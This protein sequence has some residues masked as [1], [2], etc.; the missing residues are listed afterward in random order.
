MLVVCV[1]V[2]AVMRLLR[3]SES[4]SVAGPSDGCSSLVALMLGLIYFRDTMRF[5]IPVRRHDRT[6]P[7]RACG[8][9]WQQFPTAVAPVPSEGSFAIAGTTALA[10][11]ALARRLVRVPRVR[12][13]RG[14]RARR[15]AVHLHRRRSAPIATECRRGAVVRRRDPRRSRHCACA[16]RAATTRRGWASGVSRVVGAPGRGRVRVVRHHRRRRGGSATAGRRREGVARHPQSR[17][18]RHRGGQPAGRHPVEAG[19]PRQRRDVHRVDSTVARYWRPDRP[20]PSSTAAA[21]GRLP[22]TTRVADGTLHDPPAEARASCSSRSRSRKLGGKLVPAA[23]NSPHLPQWQVARC[24]WAPTAAR[25]TSTAARRA[26]ATSTRSR[27]P[28]TNRRPTSCAPRRSTGAPSPDVL[29][30]A[31]T[32]PTRSRTRAARSPPARPRRTTRR[33]RCRTGSA[34]SSRTT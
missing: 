32:C 13:R 34:T 29:R 15:R 24:C 19:Q 16:A 28:S 2:H 8:W 20:R 5:G 9:S 23:P 11:C 22:E 17:R 31:A 27:R 6:V 4:A 7:H 12:P 25:C 33:W 21:W 26:R 18:R 14:G 3:G 10:L 30:P 1:G